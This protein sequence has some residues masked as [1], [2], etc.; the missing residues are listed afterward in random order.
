[1]AL[2]VKVFINSIFKFLI[3]KFLFFTLL[4]IAFIVLAV[5]N[6]DMKEGYIPFSYFALAVM[7]VVIAA[8]VRNVTIKSY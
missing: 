5:V 7:F 3:M 6:I 1:V 2:A 4:A 8:T